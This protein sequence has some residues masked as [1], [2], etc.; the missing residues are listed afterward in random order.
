MYII[1]LL[2][3]QSHTEATIVRNVGKAISKCLLSPEAR[4][5]PWYPSVCTNSLGC[6]CYRGQEYIVSLHIFRFLR[7]L[8]SSPRG[9]QPSF[10]QFKVA[11]EF[12]Q[13]FQD[14]K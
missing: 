1:L 6:M 12:I 10:L 3:I 11:Q 13:H 2:R 9:P 7:A 5:K 8:S 4:R 14:T